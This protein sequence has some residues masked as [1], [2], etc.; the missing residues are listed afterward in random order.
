M[1]WIEQA[2]NVSVIIAVGGS[3]LG[4]AGWII[5]PHAAEFV[6]NTVQSKVQQLESGIN[7]LRSSDRTTQ[8][9]ILMLS[10]QQQI[11]EQQNTTIIDLLRKLQIPTEET[12]T[13]LRLPRI[14]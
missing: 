5:S 8:E 10:T 1:S 7:S 9:R 13:P 11:I 3:L 4:I 12:V 14:E 2:K 6:N